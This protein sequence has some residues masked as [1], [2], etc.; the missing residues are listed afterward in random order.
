MKASITGEL[1]EEIARDYDLPAEDVDSL[2]SGLTSWLEG[3]AAN[4]LIRLKAID[5][6][7]KRSQDEMRELKLHSRVI[8]HYI[9][10][11]WKINDFRKFCI[12]A[13]ILQFYKLDKYRR[14]KTASEFDADPTEAAQDHKHY[15]FD[16]MKS[17]FRTFKKQK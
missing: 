2:I 11:N 16:L 3:L 8:L 5:Y 13:R 7:G 6:S 10:E 4:H 15:L 9:N 12:A 14:I 17:R 1:V